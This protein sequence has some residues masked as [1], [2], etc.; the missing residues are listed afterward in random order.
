MDDLGRAA[1]IA[2][3]FQFTHVMS[4]ARTR[5]KRRQLWTKLL[6]TLTT[7]RVPERPDRSEPR[8]AKRVK[9]KYPRRDAPRHKFRDRPK[10][11]VRLTIARLRRLGLM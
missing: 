10:R 11:N 3:L 1:Y 5:K 6:E 4:Q 2:F 9:H 8:A 7:D